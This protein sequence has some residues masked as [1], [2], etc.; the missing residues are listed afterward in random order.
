[1]FGK[2]LALCV[3]KNPVGTF[4]FVGSIPADLGKEVPAS[5]AAVLGCRAFK[6]EAG[7]LVEIKFPTFPTEAEAVAF[8]EAK[9]YEVA[10]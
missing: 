7:E 3:I 6:N 2:P 10:K 1:M 5:T 8:A 4:M 9:G